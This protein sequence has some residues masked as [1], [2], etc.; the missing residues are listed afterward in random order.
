MAIEIHE[1]FEDDI[2]G[3]PAAQTVTFALGTQVYEIDLNA[4]NSDM[5]KR[6]LAP[7]IARSRPAGTIPKRAPRQ[8]TRDRFTRFEDPGSQRDK[9]ERRA[10]RQWARRVGIPVSNYG[11]LRPEL[12]QAY[13]DHLVATSATSAL[14]A[15]PTR[16]LVAVP[17]AKFTEPEA[18]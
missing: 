3:S 16:N 10:A 15:K 12:L 5:L 7:F 18:S 9:D 6:V 11:Q 2:D 1:V 13:R 4:A 14:T 17:A 8:P